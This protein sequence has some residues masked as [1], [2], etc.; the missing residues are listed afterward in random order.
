MPPLNLPSSFNA[1]TT[2]PVVGGV[3]PKFNFLAA[4]PNDSSRLPP[5]LNQQ[6]SRNSISSHNNTARLQEAI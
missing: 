1:Q 2:G 4:K 5:R 3:T 6:N